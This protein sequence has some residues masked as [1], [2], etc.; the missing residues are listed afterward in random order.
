MYFI[1]AL[2]VWIGVSAPHVIVSIHFNLFSSS[3]PYHAQVFTVLQIFITFMEGAVFYNFVTMIVT[4]VGSP[5]RFVQLLK[6][7]TKP[8]LCSCSC[9]CPKARRRF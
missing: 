8:L 1:T 9:F 4:D 6:S 2:F 5:Y 7:N 3:L